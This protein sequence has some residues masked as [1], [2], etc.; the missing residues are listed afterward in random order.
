[1]YIRQAHSED[2]PIGIWSQKPQPKTLEERI[3]RGMAFK[4]KYGIR[5][6]MVFDTMDD[7]FNNVAKAWPLR[8]Y[9]IGEIGGLVQYIEPD[10]VDGIE[11]KTRLQNLLSFRK[12]NVER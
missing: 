7:S 11:T 9:V 6:G 3:E 10:P 4:K 2:W 12:Q 5:M 1:V 8:M